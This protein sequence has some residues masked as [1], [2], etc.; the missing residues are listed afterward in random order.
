MSTYIKVSMWITI[1]TT[2]VAIQFM[3]ADLSP[4]H[5][6]FLEVF[7]VEFPKALF[8]VWFSILF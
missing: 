2:F 3:M 8:Q 6:E 1:I 4:Q 7:F 5:A